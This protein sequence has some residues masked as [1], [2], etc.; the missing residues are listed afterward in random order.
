MIDIAGTQPSIPADR[1]ASAFANRNRIHSHFDDVLTTSPDDLS[2][3]RL[4]N[5][6]ASELWRRLPISRFADQS[7][8]RGIEHTIRIATSSTAQVQ[9]WYR[10]LCDFVPAIAKAA[11][12]FRGEELSEA[13]QAELSA[14]MERQM[15][16]QVRYPLPSRSF[17]D[18]KFADLPPAEAWIQAQEHLEQ[19]CLEFA[20]HVFALFDTL[21]QKNLIGKIQETSSTCRFTF[22]RRAAIAAKPQNKTE[23][24][25]RR[26]PN[27]QIPGHTVFLEETFQISDYG[28]Q[29]RHAQCVHHVRNPVLNR[30][31]ETINPLPEKY[32]C[33]IDAC[34]NWLA[35]SVRVLE[36]ELFREER[37]EWDLHTEVRRDERVIERVRRCPA[38]LFGPY[39]LAGWGELA[40]K[41]EEHRQRQEQNDV[42][43]K[44]SAKKARTYQLLAFVVAALAVAVIPFTGS[45][46]AAM[47]SLAILLGTA[48][49]IMAGY[50]AH[51]ETIARGKFSA[52]QVLTHSTLIGATV[53][54]IQ[55]LLFSIVHWSLPAFGLAAFAGAAA[56]VAF[57]VK[58]TDAELGGSR[59]G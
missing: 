38:V 55:G 35:D 8:E 27:F 57:S 1:V 37:I 17:V 43:R 6:L 14:D 30:P 32:S 13:L 39:I 11:I 47:T 54:A 22:F 36:G 49:M 42:A 29:H 7:G 12:E 24:R 51:L 41:E 21:Q 50:A 56:F 18:F 28:I 58:R 26:D 25:T 19:E 20:N 10:D 5:E 16:E 33:L 45:A 48:A 52:T 2:K 53:F 40:I 4:A 44:A 34:P 15:L 9:S 31:D 59:V 23:K 46:T 3:N